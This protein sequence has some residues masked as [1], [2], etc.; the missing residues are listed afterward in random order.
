MVS[1]LKKIE[2]YTINYY[3]LTIFH[4]PSTLLEE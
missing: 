3:S 4:L 2:F 1:V